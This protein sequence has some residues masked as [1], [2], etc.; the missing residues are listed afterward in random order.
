VLLVSHDAAL[1]EKTCDW[2]VRINDGG[3]AAAG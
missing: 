1:I 3:L 2:Q